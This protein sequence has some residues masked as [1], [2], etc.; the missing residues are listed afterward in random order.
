MHMVRVVRGFVMAV[1]CAVGLGGRREKR[2]RRRRC[3]D[4]DEL[5][6]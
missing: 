3:E 5:Q 2:E 6:H 4:P 1:V